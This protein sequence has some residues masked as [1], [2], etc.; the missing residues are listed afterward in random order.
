MT[1]TRSRLPDR[2]HRPERDHDPVFLLHRSSAPRLPT[3]ATGS[4]PAP[5]SPVL[6]TELSVSIVIWRA[7]TSDLIPAGG[8]PTPPVSRPGAFPQND[9]L[10]SLTAISMSVA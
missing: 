6:P 8:A 4:E 9:F 1:T 5:A 3:R 7:K 10:R 2:K